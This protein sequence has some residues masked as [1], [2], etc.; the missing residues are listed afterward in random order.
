MYRIGPVV[1]T[2]QPNL[3]VEELGTQ[4]LI[5]IGIAKKQPVL[6]DVMLYLIRKAAVASG[7]RVRARN[8]VYLDVT[9]GEERSCD[10][11]LKRFN[12]LF[13]VSAREMATIWDT[14]TEPVRR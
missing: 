1:V 8:V 11:N 9:N 12:R 13:V 2:A 14:L 6:I 4:V 3:W 7:Y 10:D 5:K